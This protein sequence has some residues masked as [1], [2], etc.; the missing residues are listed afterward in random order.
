MEHMFLFQTTYRLKK[1]CLNIRAV[2]QINTTLFI[3]FDTIVFI[4][5]EFVNFCILQCE[6]S[7]TLK[8]KI[9]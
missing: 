1:L 4:F 8:N 9:F 5:K 2:K 3:S 7:N 6:I